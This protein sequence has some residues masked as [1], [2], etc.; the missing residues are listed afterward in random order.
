MENLTK[1]SPMFDFIEQ[2]SGR[3]IPKP[4]EEEMKQYEREIRKLKEQED[5]L[6]KAEQ[7]QYEEIE[8][9]QQLA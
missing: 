4:E 7:M 2:I 3:P 8:D 9:D 6:E 5:D 1:D